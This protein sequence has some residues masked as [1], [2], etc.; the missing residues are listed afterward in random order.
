MH[1][2][3][4][5]KMRG[6]DSAM[7]TL[8]IHDTSLLCMEDEF[9]IHLEGLIFFCSTYYIQ[10]CTLRKESCSTPSLYP[11]TCLSLD[12]TIYLPF[13]KYQRF[14]VRTVFLHSLPYFCIVCGQI[15]AWT[16]YA[17]PL[18]ILWLVGNSNIN[19][20]SGYVLRF[21]KHQFISTLL[22]VSH[23]RL[24]RNLAGHPRRDLALDAVIVMSRSFLSSMRTWSFTF[25]SWLT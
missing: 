19:L 9:Y 3:M 14:P 8:M 2:Y 25:T 6:N 16:L 4:I 20:D 18:W 23:V 11:D 15:R 21:F 7:L 24:R 22:E 10:L 13:Y 1:I 12:I 5:C 17:L